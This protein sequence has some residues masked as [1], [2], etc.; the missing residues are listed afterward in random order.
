MYA[1]RGKMLNLQVTNHEMFHHFFVLFSKWKM[2]IVWEICQYLGCNI[3]SSQFAF[4]P[5]Q[6]MPSLKTSDPDRKF[7]GCFLLQHS[8]RLKR[9][10]K[11]AWIFTPAFQQ[12]RIRKFSCLTNYVWGEWQWQGLVHQ[13]EQLTDYQSIAIVN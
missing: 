7:C 9:T 4:P 12:Q 2:I 13:R 8:N 1:D 3:Y 10:S 6:V 11:L 5:P